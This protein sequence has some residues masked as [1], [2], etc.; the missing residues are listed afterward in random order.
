[1]KPVALRAAAALALAT[2]LLSP[3]PVLRAQQSPILAAMQDEMKRSMA[4]LRMK[5][6]PAPYFIAYELQ[7]RTVTDV[8]GRLGAV[9]ENPPRR[10]RVPA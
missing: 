6:A 7:D 8:S 4:E 3:A 9:I 5:D 2:G 10:T 1:M